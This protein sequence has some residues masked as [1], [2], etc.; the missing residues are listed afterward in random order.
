MILLIK[1]RIP[2][3]NELSCNM[4]YF[5]FYS[6]ARQGENAGGAQWVIKFFYHSGFPLQSAT[7]FVMS[8]ACSE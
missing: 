6:N 3:L 4:P 5:T 2:P 1:E 8:N 7:T